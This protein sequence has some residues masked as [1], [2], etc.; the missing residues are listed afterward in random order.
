MGFIMK[1]KKELIANYSFKDFNNN[2][3][4]LSDLFNDKKELLLIHN[5]GKQCPYC[6][7]WAD[8]FNGVLK[9]LEDKVSFAVISKD[10]PKIQKEFYLKRRWKFKMLSAKDNSFMKD[11][12]FENKKG[13]PLP[14]VSV[15]QKNKEG[16]IFRVAKDE[17]DIGDNYCIVWHF[18]DL[19]P[20]G[21]K[22]WEP[23]FDYD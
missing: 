12:G 20:S 5:M 15:F 17:F 11:M 21:S 6:T 14:G 9:H 22:D 10:S 2:N 8:G 3:V 23:K 19:L 18:F 13:G 1:F 4:Y 16:K 7:M